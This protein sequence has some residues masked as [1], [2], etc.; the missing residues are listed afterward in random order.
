MILKEQYVSIIITSLEDDL[1]KLKSATAFNEWATDECIKVSSEIL[2]GLSPTELK[3][4][5]DQ[6]R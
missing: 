2:D 4:M 5:L 1:V 3:S 6:P